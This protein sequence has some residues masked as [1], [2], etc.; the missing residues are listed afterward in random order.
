[1]KKR[2]KKIQLEPVKLRA[3]W[4][5]QPTTRVKPSAKVYTRKGRKPDPK[6]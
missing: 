4:V 6:D 1:M 2:V 5:I 3:V